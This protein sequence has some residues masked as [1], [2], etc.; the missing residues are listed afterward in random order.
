MLLPTK[1]ALIRVTQA[2]A[3]VQAAYRDKRYVFPAS[4]VV[5]LPIPNT[6]AEML[7]WWIAQELRQGLGTLPPGMTA[8]E[9]EVDESSGQRAF[10]REAL[11][12]P[13]PRDA[14]A[15]DDATAVVYLGLGSNLGDR[16]ANLAEALQS[17]RAHV[18]I[19]RV[20]PVY[21]TEP[22][23]V[24]DQPRFLNLVAQ[25]HDRARAGRAAR[26]RQADRVADGAAPRRAVRA[27]S[28]RHRHPLLRRPHRPHR[29]A[30]G[31]APA[32]RRARLRAGAALTTS[33][34][35]SGTPGSGA[36]SRELLADLGE[37]RGIV[38]VA[39]G[40]T[41]RLERDVQEESPSARIRL[42]QTGVTGLHRIIRLADGGGL[43]YAT[44]DLFVELP[45]DQKGAHMSRFSDTVEEVLE[46]LGA[47]EAPMIETLAERIAR[48]LTVGHRAER[49]DVE[50]R[51]QFPLERRAPIS[52][53]PSQELYT[54]IG[55]AAATPRR[56]VQLI[57]VEAEGMMACPCAQEMVRAQAEAR[58]REHG[59]TPEATAEV[60]SLV[61]VA[62]HNQRGRGRLLVGADRPLRAEDLVEIVEGAMSSE[63]YDLLK[64]P[65]ELFVVEKAHRHPRFVEDTVR[66]MLRT[67]RQHVPGPARTTRTCTPG[68][69]TWRPSTSTTSSPSGAAGWTRSAESCW[70]GSRG[71]ARPSRRG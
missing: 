25:G 13:G 40:L 24:T 19:E 61:P 43:F 63:N 36:P 51:A 44:L 42:D 30:R 28:H 6:T 18:R 23:L 39:R 48:A 45:P 27:A 15:R 53:K 14:T 21:E 46:D 50:I 69:R 12:S 67:L 68:R 49:A 64:R 4:D 41:A 7:A 38:R 9:V 57:G 29:D 31:A 1:S 10:Y 33:R 16:Q 58:L 65:D 59:L 20:S 37:T 60:L 55:I 54:L 56:A 62:T 70:T 34:R 52:G 32:D 22:L 5:L 71:A 66:E 35:I 47:F 17:L 11:D 26:R 8:L 3:E 2:G